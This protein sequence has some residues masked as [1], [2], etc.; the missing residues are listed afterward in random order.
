MLH[1]YM[2]E[3]YILSLLVWEKKNLLRVNHPYLPS[4]AEWSTPQLGVIS[5]H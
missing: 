1:R 5:N 2:P 4:K 3:K